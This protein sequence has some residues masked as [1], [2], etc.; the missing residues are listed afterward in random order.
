ML[1]L[2]SNHANPCPSF[3]DFYIQRET[4]SSYSPIPWA[5]STAR[6]NSK[7]NSADLGAGS[8][9]HHNAMISL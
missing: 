4:L 8:K 7:Q 3:Q 1:R 2:Q 9:P 5:R 6:A